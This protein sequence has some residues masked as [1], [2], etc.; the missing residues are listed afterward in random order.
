[1]RFE[2][3]H[4]FSLK[5][6]NYIFCTDD[7]LNDLNVK[8]LNHDTYTDILTFPLSEGCAPIEA[9][10]YISLERVTDNAFRYGNTKVK[11]L[12]RVM[13]HGVLHLC[14]FDD[15][16]PESILEMRDKENF[17]LLRFI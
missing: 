9:E 4:R 5:Q 8:Y 3:V 13:I 12:L 16:S 6:L 7:Y 11:E 15:H 10:I 1:M 14:G 17:Y 2:S